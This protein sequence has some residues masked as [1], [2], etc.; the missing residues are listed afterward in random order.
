[1]HIAINSNRS[2]F[3]QNIKNCSNQGIDFYIQNAQFHKILL[4][5]AQ[6]TIWDEISHPQRS[7]VD[8][9]TKL[10][11]MAFKIYETLFALR[12]LINFKKLN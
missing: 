8:A 9:L 6:S 7:V 2:N 5:T 12:L 11:I 1:M 10:Q 4:R 3:E